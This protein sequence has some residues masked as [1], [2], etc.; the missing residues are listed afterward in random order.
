MTPFAGDISLPRLERVISGPDTV[1]V[2]GDELDRRD[3]T[4]VVVV[5]GRTLGASPLLDRVRRPL[6]D[7]CV[8]VFTAARQHVPASSV[9][10]L[11]RVIDRE[12]VDGVVSF[13]GG[14][15][16]DTAKVGSPWA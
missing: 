11:L 3:V 15:P 13:G 7:R 8:A 16:I 4:R 10:E 12:R 1:D 14:S 5:T 2:L 6:G 9:T